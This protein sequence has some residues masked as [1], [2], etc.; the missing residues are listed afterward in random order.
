M[1]A[2]GG[3]EHSA[4]GLPLPDRRATVG[5]GRGGGGV[6]V[7]VQHCWKRV[8]RLPLLHR[9]HDACLQPLPPGLLHVPHT[10]S[11][12]Q[13]GAARRPGGVGWDGVGG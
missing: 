1:R 3:H 12:R 13:Q 7:G 9:V 2:T 6:G 10:Q 5:R 4:L 11:H 8:V